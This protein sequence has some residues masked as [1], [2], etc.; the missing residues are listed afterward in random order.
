[1][2]PVARLLVIERMIK[3]DQMFIQ[4]IRK[5]CHCVNNMQKL[6]CSEVFCVCRFWVCLVIKA[7]ISLVVFYHLFMEFT[8]F[9]IN[10]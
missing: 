4:Q 8:V 1:M 7:M 5:V 2:K 9:S 6:R 10:Q 3:L